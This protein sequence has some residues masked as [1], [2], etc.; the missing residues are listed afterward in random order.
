MKR[1]FLLASLAL[2]ALVLFHS[3][4]GPRATTKYFSIPP[5]RTENYTDPSL[6]R[7]AEDPE[8]DGASVVVREPIDRGSWPGLQSRVASLVESGLMRNRY[9][10]RNRRLFE[11]AM[12]KL[13]DGSDYPT[14]RAKTGTD[15]IFE[16]NFNMEEYTVKDY[17]VRTGGPKSPFTIPNPL[18]KKNPLHPTYTVYGFSIEIKVI[19]LADN[20]IAG[21]YKYYQTPCV[22]GCVVRTFDANR[23]TY[24]VP[25]DPTKVSD[26]EESAR[27]QTRWERYE[28]Q[29]GEFIN[30]IVVPNMFAEMKG[31]A[32]VAAP[33]Q[34]AYSQYPQY[35]QYPVAQPTQP[36]APVAAQPQPPV[37]A[38]PLPSKEEQARLLQEAVEK[39]LALRKAQD[40]EQARLAEEAR[41]KE[42]AQR[43]AEAE[44]QARLAEEAER[45][46]PFAQNTHEMAQSVSDLLR[47]AILRQEPRKHAEY[48]TDLARY[49]Q[50]KAKEREEI[51]KYILS[52]A[53]PVFKY[54][55]V[56]G[57]AVFFCKK[58]DAREFSLLLFLDETC[59]GIGSRN[60][61]FYAALP[62][63]PYK[64]RIS[65]FSVWGIGDNA[66]FSTP[67][68]FIHKTEYAFAWNRNALQDADKQTA[69]SP[70]SNSYLMVGSVSDLILQLLTAQEPKKHTQFKTDLDRYQQLKPVAK[71]EIDAYIKTLSPSIDDDPETQTGEITFLCKPSKERDAS[72]LLFLDNQCVGIGTR[73]KGLLAKLPQNEYP[74]GL[75]TYSLHNS[76][77]ELLSSP[78]NFKFK[79]EYIFIWNRNTLTQSN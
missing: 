42:R 20:K 66:L 33:A 29:I 31:Q 60:K 15:L 13:E 22:E 26:S 38:D 28:K 58:A 70:S 47:Q 69:S 30:D 57:H 7:F 17:Y 79:Q 45:R 46:I 21:V 68:N 51:H 63:E 11:N 2:T 8:H 49:R 23:L 77:N 75:H 43:Q 35:P 41:E 61:G 10:P 62:K 53:A 67:V 25:I 65:A 24:Y 55:P 34:P 52:L 36:Q 76:S 18:D 59:I 48:A 32:P 3:C 1:T 50:L 40:E 64:D 54:E 37:A 4:G 14:I 19:L 16:I 78:I 71:I 74:D 12:E 5:E 73:N 9:N 44:E 39:E 56:D 27:V 72:L 6:H